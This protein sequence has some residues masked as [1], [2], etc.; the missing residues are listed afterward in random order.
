[1]LLEMDVLSTEN[2]HMYQ[3]RNMFLFWPV[4]TTAKSLD[5]Q[6]VLLCHPSDIRHDK[7]QGKRDG[8]GQA[9][10]GISRNFICRYLINNHDSDITAKSREYMPPS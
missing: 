5:C 7:A 6:L 3:Q 10:K 8:P 2:P 1:M 9:F 4:V